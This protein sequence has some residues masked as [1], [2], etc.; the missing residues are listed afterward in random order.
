MVQIGH[1]RFSFDFWKKR[2]PVVGTVAAY[3]F[4]IWI[5]WL[6]THPFME[7]FA[8]VTDLTTFNHEENNFI[9]KLDK[10]QNK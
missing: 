5:V 10:D 4:G 6:R 1:R 7:T 3:D 8:V 2:Q 9:C